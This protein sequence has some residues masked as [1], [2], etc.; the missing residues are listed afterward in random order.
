MLPWI[1]KEG[2]LISEKLVRIL[3]VVF[4]GLSMSQAA[5]SLSSEKEIHL[6]QDTNES[7]SSLRKMVIKFKQWS[8]SKLQEY[9]YNCRFFAGDFLPEFLVPE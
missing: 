7:V 3:I 1:V 5:P 8:Y 2:K 9:T 4:L 6:A